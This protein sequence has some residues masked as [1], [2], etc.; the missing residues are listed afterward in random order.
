MSEQKEFNISGAKIYLAIPSYLGHV[1]V[2]TLLAVAQLPLK[3]D[4]CGAHMAIHAERGNGVI[5]EVR[6]KLITG[7][8]NSDAEYLFWLDDDIVFNADDL[9][10]IVALCTEKKVVGATYPS[11]DGSNRFYIHPIDRYGPFEFDEMGLIKAKGLGMGFVCMHRSVVEAVCKDKPTYKKSKESEELIDVFRNSE[12]GGEY[13]GE[14]INFLYDLY[15]LGYITY[16]D[17]DVHLQHV[18]TKYYDAKFTIKR[19]GEQ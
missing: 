19:Q 11:R 1:P 13:W 3:L 18:G 10:R 8:L 7:F 15:A 6:N 17:A 2:E 4:A 14:D 5:T 16:V 9:I 12:V